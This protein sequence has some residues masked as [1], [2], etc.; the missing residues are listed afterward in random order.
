MQD[1]DQRQNHFLFTWIWLTWRIVE[2]AALDN[3]IIYLL[4]FFSAN[5]V[6]ASSI[7]SLI[8]DLD[9]R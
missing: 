5:L 6:C 2:A 3:A 4:I 7:S 9:N 8:T 1:L